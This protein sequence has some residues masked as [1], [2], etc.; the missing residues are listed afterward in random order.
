M[1]F[2]LIIVNFICGSLM[3]SY[4]LGILAR[5]N[6]NTVGDG[7][8]GAANLWKAAGYKYGLTGVFLDFLK[9]YV[10]LFLLIESRYV[11]GY[12]IIPIA[13]A[14][15]L[16]HA[17]SP[18]LKFR[19]GKAI[20]VTFGV[21][22]ALTRFKVA[23]VY[24]LILALLLITTRIINKGKSPST[25][26]DSFQTVFGFFLL[27]VY[28]YMGEFSPHTL[29]IWLG[30]LLILLYTNKKHLFENDACHSPKLAGFCR[31]NTS[32]SKS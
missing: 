16:G 19:G 8:P 9:G 24:A 11:T 22:S 1:T 14:P 6:L 29:W 20:A 4:L 17:L 7:N 12:A 30:N 3:F 15:I 31:K 27:S 13:L 2:L 32:V 26:A 23:I 10:P 5:K 28:L 18:F 25:K 21:W